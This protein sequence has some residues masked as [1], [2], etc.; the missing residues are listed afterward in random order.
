[1][2]LQSYACGQWLTGRDRGNR[3]AATRPSGEPRRQCV[4]DGPRFCRNAVACA[5]TS[6]GPALAGADVPRNARALLK[7]LAKRLSE[8]KEE[9]YFLVFFGRV[10][11]EATRRSTL[12]AASV[13]CSRLP[14]R[15]PGNCPTAG[16]IWTVRWKVSRRAGPSSASTFYVPRAKAAAV[17]INA[18]NFPVWGMLEK[19]APAIL[20]GVPVIVK[21]RQ[22]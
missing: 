14:A 10:R 20:A 19:F 15:V 4:V 22:R 21:N 1:M 8:L 2:Q 12:M 9:F 5:K 11:P 7:S 17:H 18:F 3:H 13:R 6:A 16:C